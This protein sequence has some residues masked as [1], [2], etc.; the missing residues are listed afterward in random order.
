MNVRRVTLATLLIGPLTA[1]LAPASWA[2]TTYHVSQSVGNDTADGQ[3]PATAW[4]TLT[5]A[6]Q[7]EYAPGD[8]IL[9]KRGDAW[10]EELRPPG[11]GTAAN[12]ITIGS[13]DDGPR[14]LIDR[15]DATGNN[16]DK[17][18]I[19]L[20]NIGGYK[21]KGIEFARFGR[22][23]FVDFDKGVHGKDFVW[24]EDCY[25]HDALY[26]NCTGWYTAKNTPLT[27][28]A[29]ASSFDHRHPVAHRNHLDRRQEP[30]QWR[31][32]RVSRRHP[33]S[34]GRHVQPEATFTAGTVQDDRFAERRAHAQDRGQGDQ[35][36]RLEGLPHRSRCLP[37]RRIGQLLEHDDMRINA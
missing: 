36:P 18:C 5:R 27:A 14:P 23:V 26:Y 8:S 21:I 12:P 20:K 3:S 2:A 15:Q 22:G 9:L 31:G 25:F 24:I 10:N 28:K 16:I 1:G 17:A 4:K 7:A 37:G 19:R 13:Y 33:R 11:E 29:T 34:P 6:S 32:G 35:E 30:R